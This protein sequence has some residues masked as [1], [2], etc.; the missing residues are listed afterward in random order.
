MN[1]YTH[2]GPEDAADEMNRMQQPES[3]GKEQEAL[4]GKTDGVKLSRK[5]IRAG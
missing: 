4:S 5:H 3:T 2:L 1:T